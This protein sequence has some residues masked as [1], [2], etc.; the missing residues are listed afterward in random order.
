MLFARHPHGGVW[1]HG[2]QTVHRHRDLLFCQLNRAEGEMGGGRVVSLSLKLSSVTNRLS[3]SEQKICT[4]AERGDEVCTESSLQGWQSVHVDRIYH[5]NH[6][7]SPSQ[8][9]DNMLGPTWSRV[10]CFSFTRLFSCTLKIVN[11]AWRYPYTGE[12]H[13]YP[14]LSHFFPRTTVPF[15]T[16]SMALPVLPNYCCYC[17]T[18]CPLPY[19]CSCTL[20]H[21]YKVS[22]SCFLFVQA[23]LWSHVALDTMQAE[24][25]K[26]V[27]Y[28]NS[29]KMVQF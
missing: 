26:A 13:V 10:I 1:R 16:G 3:F 14:S 19:W 7:G 27:V 24:T 8:V 17:F 9:H 6:C 20:S 23:I 25:K 29:S 28:Y 18:A 2:K 4:S 21:L 5:S 12:L 11:L 22:Q 15:L